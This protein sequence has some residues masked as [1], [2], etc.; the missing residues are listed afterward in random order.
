MINYKIIGNAMKSSHEDRIGG[1]VL[2][3]LVF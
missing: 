1:N 2:D 3:D